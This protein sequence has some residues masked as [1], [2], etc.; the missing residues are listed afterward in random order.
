MRSSS[1]SHGQVVAVVD[2]RV[3][4]QLL[5]ALLLEQAVDERD[6]V[7][8]VHVEDDAADGG[9]DELLVELLNLGVHRCP[10]R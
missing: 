3:V 8:Q 4:D 6:L 1:I 9:L 2:E 5:Q 7:R 10:D